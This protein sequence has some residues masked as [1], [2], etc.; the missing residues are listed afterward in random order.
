MGHVRHQ[1]LSTATLER[2]DRARDAAP[3]RVVFVAELA[4]ARL[5]VRAHMRGRVRFGC[6][7]CAFGAAFLASGLLSGLAASV[8][9]PAVLAPSVFALPSPLVATVAAMTGF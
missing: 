6:C 5:I 4:P 2:R 7:T 3:E 8:L 9:A 1:R